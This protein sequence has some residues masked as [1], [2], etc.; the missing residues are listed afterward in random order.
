MTRFLIACGF[1]IVLANAA[2]LGFQ[3]GAASNKPTGVPA[4][5]SLAENPPKSRIESTPIV[6]WP[7]RDGTPMTPSEL[8]AFPDTEP[9]HNLDR[10]PQIKVIPPEEPG[11]SPN[12]VVDLPSVND[13]PERIAAFNRSQEAAY[14]KYVRSRK[15]Q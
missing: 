1:L 7:E 6:R 8:A 10:A 13:S 9:I 5:S 15:S 12:D 4:V 2:M 11:S 3:F 14:Q